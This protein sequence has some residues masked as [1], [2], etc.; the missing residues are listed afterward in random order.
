[1]LRM[2]CTVELAAFLKSHPDGPLVIRPVSWGICAIAGFVSVAILLLG[3]ALLL[4]N[5]LFSSPDAL[6]VGVMT[7]FVFAAS[8]IVF[9]YFISAA[10]R[11]HFRAANAVQEQLR[12]FSFY[13]DTLCHCC[14]V[15]HINPKTG[16]R[17][18]CDRQTIAGCLEHWF[19]SV[20]AFDIVVQKEVSAAFEHRVMRCLLPYAWLTGATVPVLWFG[21]HLYFLYS[22][23][24]V[25]FSNFCYCLG[26]WL[27]NIPVIVALWLR[28]PRY[29]RRRHAT[30][31]REVMVN[32]ACSSLI[33]IM[34]LVVRGAETAVWHSVP[35]YG[36]VTCTSISLLAAA[37]FLSD[38]GRVFR[39]KSP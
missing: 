1:M 31:F 28:I 15:N 9:M 36:L 16:Q 27:G 6:W 10:T 29:C 35:T 12:T 26:W 18:F 3:P 38:C 17:M 23:S 8:V 14:S 2:W 11:A 39:R 32:M 33:G 21:I 24:W 19:G 22:D 34:F 4:E 5:F 20:P 37:L 30:K 7:A 25:A 13:N